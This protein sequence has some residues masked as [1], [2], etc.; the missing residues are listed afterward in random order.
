[1]EMKMI[2]SVQD[3]RKFGYSNTV[4][5]DKGMTLLLK[6]D[7]FDSTSMLIAGCFQK[8]LGTDFWKE[9]SILPPKSYGK[10]LDLYEIEIRKLLVNQRTTPDPSTRYNDE[11]DMFGDIYIVN[12]RKYEDKNL[13]FFYGFFMNLKEYFDKGHPLYISTV[14]QEEIEANFGTHKAGDSYERLK[15]LNL[16]G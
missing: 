16:L 12:R 1:M 10:I 13:E 11:V 9:D 5:T 14:T 7:V 3:W 4:H 8:V 15:D 6:D 2:L